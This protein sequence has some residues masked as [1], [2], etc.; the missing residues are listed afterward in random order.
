MLFYCKFCVNVLV[1]VFVLKTLTVFRT[2]SRSEKAETRTL[3]TPLGR[4][5][6]HDTWEIDKFV[7]LPVELCAEVGGPPV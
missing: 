5:S 7:T 1:F 6:L 4:H 2:L 3:S